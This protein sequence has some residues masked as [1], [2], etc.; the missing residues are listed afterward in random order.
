ME[1]EC[2]LVVTRVW[3]M[4]G[5]GGMLVKVYKLPVTRLKTSGDIMYNVVIRASNTVY[6]Q[7]VMRVDLK[8]SHYKKR[9]NYVMGWWH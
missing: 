8:Y 6:W 5:K 7:V 9:N 2:R 1:T 4:G 3:S